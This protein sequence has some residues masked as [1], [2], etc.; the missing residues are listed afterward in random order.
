MSRLSENFEL[1]SPYEPIHYGSSSRIE[2]RPST[3]S[4]KPVK[5]K[6]PFSRYNPIKGSE[7]DWDQQGLAPTGP[8]PGGDRQ[9]TSAPLGPGKTGKFGT[10][11]VIEILLCASAVLATVPFIWLAI[12]MAKYHGKRVTAHDS[13]FIKQSTTTV[14]T[15]FTI[16]FAAVVGT[17]L[18]R[19][20][21]YC[22]GKGVKIGFLEQIM[23][24]RT[25]FAAVTTQISL[26]LINITA[27]ILLCTW[28][29]SPLGSQACL[30]LITTKIEHTVSSS[31]VS[32]VDTITNQVFD[33]TSGVSS[34]LTSLKPTY[35]STILSPPATQ[36]S[37][38]D[39]WGNVKIP[40]MR[41]DL[42]K[43]DEGWADLTK[44]SFSEDSYSALVGVPIA[45][46]AN[47][48]SSF[49]IE[50]TYISLDCE[51][52]KDEPLVDIRT[53][54]TTAR[55]GT[56]L[57]PNTTVTDGSVGIYP[58]WQVAMD[59]FVSNAY[60]YG[61]PQQLENFTSDEVKQ[62]NFLF[63]TRNAV[64]ICKIDQAY[65]E[66][67]VS[68]VAQNTVST[69][70]CAVRAQRLS[71]RKHAPSAVTTFSFPSTFEY[72][73]SEW[74]L[75][76]DKL[77]SSGY[78]SL[79]EYYLQNTSAQFILAG[80]GR[81]YANYSNVT[82]EQFSVRLGQLLNTWILAGQ[83]S[84]DTMAYNLD[85]QNITASYSEGEPV[86]VCS[87]GWLVAYCVSILVML[88]AALLTIWCAFHTNIPDVLSYCSSLTRDSR[89][90]EY[91]PGGGSTMDGLQRARL[92]RDVEIKLGDV[93]EP[94]GLAAAPHQQQYQQG[95]FRN[96]LP[97]NQLGY[98]AIGL[99]DQVR[100]ARRNTLYA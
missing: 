5:S 99:S 28:T 92:M 16:L 13:E 79:A 55:N 86:Y 58:S 85:H 90:F 96:E 71:S 44:S 50:T 72:L 21:T 76:T 8:P 20:G 61:Y 24:S 84:A 19:F 78:S 2:P 25:F 82:A 57:G 51:K 73:A 45:N 40:W 37:S 42:E 53:N 89:Y 60:F 10:D 91:M 41:D 47:L 100:V 46:L 65:V 49:V 52:P 26:G 77:S 63:Q 66:S 74:I 29:F 38:M 75:A 3:T 18:K 59:Q 87:W 27:I 43:D 34:L 88:A 9:F 1:S 14:S 15:L 11:L 62:A 95:G 22:L 6:R 98:L 70:G 67:N 23:Q 69:P 81:E 83:V 64:S 80:N 32:H 39:L 31:L 93:G 68:C 33:S 35:V 36:N 17:T 94:P 12:A 48:N 30:R 4:F 97:L 7:D 56:F 54:F